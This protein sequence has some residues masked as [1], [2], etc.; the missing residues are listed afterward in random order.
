[1]KLV[2]IHFLYAVDL[3]LKTRVFFVFRRKESLPRA[4]RASKV[5]YVP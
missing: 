5:F 1:M 3:T 4:R 2:G